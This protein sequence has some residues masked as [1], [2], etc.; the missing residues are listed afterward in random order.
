MKSNQKFIDRAKKN[1][2]VNF[3]QKKL[4]Y[5]QTHS[6]LNWLSGNTLVDSRFSTPNKVRLPDLI[7]KGLPEIILE[8]D[9]SKLHGELA[10]ENERTLK[11]N[12]DYA[13]ANRPFFVINEDLAKL[14][15]LDQ[16]AL[17]TYLYYHT[18]SQ[19]RAYQI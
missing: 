8:H 17:A 16:A 6:K 11:R 13:R 2:T 19:F 3:D 12:Q 5:I 1:A 18:L 4:E 10:Y 7:I 9:S 15:G 14:L